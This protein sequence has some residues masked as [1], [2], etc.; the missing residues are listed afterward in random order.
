MCPS[1]CKIN[2]CL[3]T[4][5]AQSPTS[6]RSTLEDRS[7]MSFDRSLK[8]RIAGRFRTRKR[9]LRYNMSGDTTPLRQRRRNARYSSVYMSSAEASP[10][11]NTPPSTH[12]GGIPNPLSHMQNDLGRS[13]VNPLAAISIE[14]ATKELDRLAS[15]VEEASIMRRAVDARPESL[16]I[17][18]QSSAQS[19][20]SATPDVKG[21]FIS[22]TMT[23]SISTKL[24]S[25][26]VS[27]TSP[28]A[29]PQ[30][31]PIS[32]V[33]TPRDNI[34]GA[35]HALRR[36]RRRKTSSKLSEI[37]TYEGIPEDAE[38]EV[39]LSASTS[40]YGP[41]T[42]C[43]D[44][45]S[46]PLGSSLLSPRSPYGYAD[47]YKRGASPD[48][49]IDP[50]DQ[51]FERALL[52]QDQPPKVIQAHSKASRSKT[53][54][55]HVEFAEPLSGCPTGT[56]ESPDDRYL[57]PGLRPFLRSTSS[58]PSLSGECRVDLVSLGCGSTNLVS[59]SDAMGPVVPTINM[60]AQQKPNLALEG[61]IC[62]PKLVAG[63]DND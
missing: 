35:L 38:E 60:E 1:H 30:N 34:T 46:G 32:G 28:S 8:I 43:T 4:G 40:P 49:R 5:L 13:S 9:S 53:P 23:E 12:R 10:L 22:G 44:S 56:T 51:A 2:T 27:P 24:T 19:I 39:F 26:V 42:S 3:L 7:N 55:L 62:E 29:T 50:V 18:G 58:Y 41:T 57:S 14:V 45:R 16:K 54:G 6:R 61:A 21:F 17:S 59:Q 52:T 11:F 25:A 48:A 20:K 47:S 15:R 31:T 36:Y 63:S 33:G 37:Y